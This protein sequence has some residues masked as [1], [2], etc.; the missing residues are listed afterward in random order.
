VSETQIDCDPAPFLFREA[1]GVDAR[2]RFDQGRLAVVDM[3]G[4]ADEKTLHEERLQPDDS[5]R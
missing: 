5:G 4:G 3:T 2:E 1:V